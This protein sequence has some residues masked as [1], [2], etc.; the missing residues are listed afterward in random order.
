[1]KLLA[2]LLPDSSGYVNFTI[3]NDNNKSYTFQVYASIGTYTAAASKTVVVPAHSLK[4]VALTPVLAADDFK[5]I[6]ELTTSQYTLEVDCAISGTPQIVHQETPKV[7][8]TAH[9]VVNWN[10]PNEIAGWVTPHDPA[11]EALI[12]SAKTYHPDRALVGYQG[13]G[14]H[15]SIV[16]AQAR[17]IYDALQKD[18]NITYVNSATS[19]MGGQRVL[20][21][22]DALSGGHA[23]CIDGTVL[24]ASALENIGI[25]PVIVLLPA[26]AFVGWRTWSGSDTLDFLETTMIGSDSFDSAEAH[27]LAEYASEVDAGHF[28]SCVSTLTY[29]DSLRARGLTPLMRQKI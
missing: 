22:A 20:F 15:D 13:T 6:T 7:F 5:T 14:D 2:G 1:M 23:N 11:V 28:E 27:G 25:Q 26:H 24:F 18:F 8:L 19:F 3:Q 4:K 29:V 21:P 17:A 10:L 9:D 16:A 12:D